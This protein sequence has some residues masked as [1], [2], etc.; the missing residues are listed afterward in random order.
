ML[1]I[2]GSASQLWRSRLSIV[3]IISFS[4]DFIL[5][6]TWLILW[7]SPQSQV[8]HGG[9]DRNKWHYVCLL[10]YVCLLS[11]LLSPLLTGSGGML[12]SP[13]LCLS[14]TKYWM[15]FEARLL[16]L[17]FHCLINKLTRLETGSIYATTRPGAEV[18]P[19]LSPTTYKLLLQLWSNMVPRY[20]VVCWSTSWD[21]GTQVP[22]MEASVTQN[23]TSSPRL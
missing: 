4:C 21:Y 23:C 1:I 20:E 17:Y 22:G 3:K 7:L 2:F 5:Y 6:W 19:G 11:L 9:H 15:A 14:H 13:P 10:F 8:N 12:F 18:L 16:S